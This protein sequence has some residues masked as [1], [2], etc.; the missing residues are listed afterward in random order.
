MEKGFWALISIALS[1]NVNDSGGEEGG[2]GARE[3]HERLKHFGAEL[4]VMRGWDVE[5][6]SFFPSS[7]LYILNLPLDNIG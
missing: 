5:P 4:C 2:R 7:S 3:P 1:R 6:P